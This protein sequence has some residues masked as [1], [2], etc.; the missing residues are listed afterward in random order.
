MKNHELPRPAFR[1]GNVELR[2]GKRGA[3]AARVATRGKETPVG[4][5]GEEAVS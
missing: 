5:L 1:R 2:D 4:A 3:T